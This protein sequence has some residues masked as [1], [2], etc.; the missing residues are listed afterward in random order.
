MKFATDKEGI[1]YQMLV[2]RWLVEKL[3][4]EAPDALAA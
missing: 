3:Q 2:Q 1:P 4:E